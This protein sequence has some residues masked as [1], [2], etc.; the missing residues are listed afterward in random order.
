MTHFAIYLIYLLQDAEFQQG[1]SVLAEWLDNDRHGWIFF[2]FIKE[3]E[4]K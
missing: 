3:G 1:A 2:H 4:E